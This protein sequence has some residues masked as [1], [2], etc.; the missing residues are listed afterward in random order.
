MMMMKMTMKMKIFNFTGIAADLK[1]VI[2]RT[3]M[4]MRVTIDLLHEI[5]RSYSFHIQFLSLNFI[6]I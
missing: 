1:K 3:Q 6:K 4:M 2:L 5:F